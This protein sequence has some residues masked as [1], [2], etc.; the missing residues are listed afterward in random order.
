MA[1]APTISSLSPASGRPGETLQVN[2][3]GFGPKAGPAS[4]V[5]VRLRAGGAPEV[6]AQVTD[7][8]QTKIAIRVPETTA[9]GSGGIADVSVVT[10]DGTSNR[11]EFSVL[12]PDRPVVNALEPA[13][14][15]PGTPLT[16]R[17]R[18]FGV[19]PFGA[20]AGVFVRAATG[21]P[22]HLPAESW[23]ATEI[24]AELPPASAVDGPG[25]KSLTVRTLWGESDAVTL[26]I[27]VPPEI[28]SVTPA[29][30]FPG[31]ELTIAGGA[32]G[33]PDAAGSR[34][35]IVPASEAP[36]D[37]V[38]ESWTNAEVRASLPRAIAAAVAGAA[39]LRVT[40][41]WGS[42]TVNVQIDG[43]PRVSGLPV[44]VLPVRLET[45]FGLDG[46]EL[47]VRVYP[48][49]IHVDTHEPALT[50]DEAAAAV[51][52]AAEPGE[53]SWRQIVARF[54]ATRGEWIVRADPRTGSRDRA[55]T[56]APCTAILPDRWFAFAYADDEDHEPLATGWGR[57]V[58]ETL[59]VGPD[60]A[61][62]VDDATPVDEGM[63]WMLDFPTA[64]R[65]GMGLRIALP[66][67]APARIA[68]LVVVG[69]R[70]GG[71]GAQL[72]GDCLAAH[73]Y[74]RGIGILPEGTPTNNSEKRPAGFDSRADA[75]PPG[76]QTPPPSGSYGAEAARA[77]GLAGRAG[78]L[79]GGLEHSA[80]GAEAEAG[81][82]AMNVALWPA[83]WGYFLEHMMAPATA[84]APPILPD[85]AA[86]TGRR[87]F[88][89]NVR[90]C[91]PLPVLRVGNQPY[92]ILPV[93][94]LPTE[95]SA[96]ALPLRPLLDFLETL[97]PIWRRSLAAVPRPGRPLAPD[98]D[99]QPEDS[100][101]SALAMLPRSV[102]QRGRTILGS[103]YVDAAWRFMHAAL[104]PD[105]WAAQR[106][107]T[108]TVLASLGLDWAP[109]LRDATFALDYFRL[110]GTAIGPVV[111]GRLSPDYV[112][113]LAETPRPA[114]RALRD[115]GLATTLG[116]PTPRPLLYLLLRHALLIQYVFAAEQ[117]PPARPWRRGEP[118]LLDIDQ[119]E[120][121][122]RL[123]RQPITWDLLED[124]H[125]SGVGKGDF[126]D[127]H[128]HQSGET[129]ALG[130]LGELRDAIATLAAMPAN[131]LERLM[132]EALDLCSYRLDAWIGSFASARLAAVGSA[133]GI[134]LGGY[135]FVEDLRPNG[136]G[137]QESAGYVHAPSPGHAIT[138]AILAAGHL[139]HG[140]HDGHQPFGIDLSS[141]RVRL[142]QALVDGVRQGQSLATLLGY[143]F[144]RAM[145]ENG[146]ARFIDD[147]RAFAPQPVAA[148]PD[149][150]GANES[151]A[152]RNVVDGL[153]LQRRWVADGRRL[154]PE[155]PGQ[156]A[157]DAIRAQLLALDDLVDAV[158]DALIAEAVYQT[159]RGNPARAAAALD[160]AAHPVGPPPDLEMLDSPG[161]GLAV[162]HRL[163][164][165]LPRAVDAPLRW[166]PDPALEAR[167][168][169]EP[170]LNAWADA[171]L[172]D[173]ARVGLRVDYLPA[174][175]ARDAPPVATRSLRL[176]DISP[177]LSA[178][179]VVE[180]ATSSDG[181]QRT[182]IEQ[183]IVFDALRRR[184]FGVAAD[185]VVRIAPAEKQKDDDLTL[186]ELLE[187]A[188]TLR[189]TIAHARPLGPADLAL[190]GSDEPLA[191][192]DDAEIVGRATA[193]KAALTALADRVTAA[194][195]GGT[196]SESLRSILLAASYF[197]VVGSVPAS[198]DGDS[199]DDRTQLRLQLA[200]VDTDIRRRLGAVAAPP[201]AAS[202]ELE[203]RDWAIASLRAIFGETFVAL[204]LL[205]PPGGA[206]FDPTFADSDALQSGDSLAATSW[207]Q[208]L[209]RVRAGFQRL[210]D[211]LVLDEAI[212]ADDRARFAVAQLPRRIGDR[213]AALAFTPGAGP[214]TGRLSIAAHL[215]LATPAAGAPLCG[216]MID[217]IS[218][219]LPSPERTTAT[220][221]HFDQPNA[222]AP[223]AILVGVPPATE[224]EWTIELLRN[225]VL[226]A[227]DLAK[228]RMVDLD[229]LQEAGQFLPATYFAMN[230]TGAT[231][232]TDFVGGAGQPLGMRKL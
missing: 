200:A 186:A 117:L 125:T 15:I 199:A 114:W 146:L 119:I 28:A 213:W 7:W 224:F 168:A 11:T 128:Q 35:T 127:A 193:A 216:L 26:T 64:E 182:E 99:N 196:D 197:G 30:V 68:R 92:G 158:G 187:V 131:Q 50:A 219:V 141:G 54:G 194:V 115:E 120:D 155:W 113:K 191:A 25:D 97:R 210:S 218:E 9:L 51:T 189:D 167:A 82:R 209:S 56:R 34:V 150:V 70:T 40:T 130:E 198:A 201:D 105:W 109:R 98:P 8:K 55:W 3:K 175:A 107:A 179:D 79:F 232:A 134:H 102:A 111:D 101:L 67:G 157:A 147:F 203:A 44:A 148:T 23:S 217:E 164:V 53:D 95:S 18:G 195:A 33:P 208:R 169:A 181:S 162:T 121:D 90:A 149:G 163:V 205:T 47:L 73:R 180:T 74:T 226:D 192:V 178:I 36:V 185:A 159:A 65:V 6:P 207:I 152:A 46:S 88:I 21:D 228:L 231:V 85:G 2:G 80:E 172:G 176:A 156:D 204:P 38:V 91:G 140:E 31:D 174:G 93:M 49:D 81:R 19:A 48:D 16:V 126:L 184:P 173:P 129:G 142:V 139:A 211:T 22:L 124:T 52:Y 37:L 135:G 60:P 61:A 75:P 214:P 136:A 71:A 62:T 41:E 20:G 229:A 84:G 223:Q 145:Q 43:P 24:R 94:P 212:N 69:V 112:A 14:G 10:A 108:S 215:P 161:S 137:S 86:R 220:A 110:A 103:A 138:A 100:L 225:T 57:R 87:H 59:A 206:S 106:A 177:P 104:G 202:G 5:A 13:R 230:S 58:P 78:E 1:Q 123:D 165:M 170:R 32:F 122:L 89:E 154:G 66:A 132:S 12:E 153:A 29:S 27:G 183:R 133:G 45:R 17:G 222:T 151:I 96:P 72:L 227:L 4:R 160:A 166:A 188:R 118:E 39:T 76:P 42:A 63:R 171:V 77:L 190:P 221:F 116:M 83:T 144:E 143:R